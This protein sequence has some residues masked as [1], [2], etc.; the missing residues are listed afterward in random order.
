MR[1]TCPHCP[2]A[3]AHPPLSAGPQ[4]LHTVAPFLWVRRGQRA[5]RTEPFMLGAKSLVLSSMIDLSWGF[6][7]RWE[8]QSAGVLQSEAA[9]RHQRGTGAV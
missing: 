6:L 5:A 2:P 4:G 7:S 8:K 3:L 1:G 9:L